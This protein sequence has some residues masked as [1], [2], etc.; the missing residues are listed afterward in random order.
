MAVATGSKAFG[1][2][3]TEHGVAA[4]F[5][6]EDLPRQ[7]RNRVRALLAGRGDMR[8]ERGRLYLRP[9]G[10]FLDITKNDDLAW[11]IA[12]CRRL[13]KLDLLVLDPL[14]DIS[15]AAE[16]KSDEMS[17]VMRRLR[18]VA[19]ML[20]CTVVVVHHTGKLS[21]HTAKR[22]PGQ[23]LRGSSAIHGSI[24]SGIY[25]ADTAGD[26]IAK[27]T[28]TVD[29]EVKGARSGG[30]G[31]A[32]TTARRWRHRPVRASR[33]PRGRRHVHITGPTCGGMHSRRPSDA[34]P[35]P[36]PNRGGDPGQVQT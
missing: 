36:G 24:D 13:G 6:A 27:F 33:R 31:V 9:R 34:W 32:G 1:E 29:S 12:S 3:Y 19:E 15:S 20:G 35:G 16:D 4:Y 22:R 30:G 8:I 23:R 25:L 14:R 18:L 11:L 26:G 21:A 5:F 7:A 17:P 28:N 10:M 2:F